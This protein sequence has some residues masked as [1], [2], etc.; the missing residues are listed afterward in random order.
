MRCLGEPD[1]CQCS[2]S[3]AAATQC[4]SA[5]GGVGWE[6][7]LAC[8]EDICRCPLQIDVRFARISFI[9]PAPSKD[10]ALSPIRRNRNC[11]TCPEVEISPA[12]A[13]TKGLV[14]VVERLMTSTQVPGTRDHQ[15]PSS[16]PPPPPHPPQGEQQQ[17]Q[18]IVAGCWLCCGGD[19]HLLVGVTVLYV[20][21]VNATRCT[22]IT[23][24][25]GTRKAVSAL[26]RMA[27]SMKLIP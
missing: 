5:E 17:E 25:P 22:I 24:T 23:T 8:I 19:G 18:K 16:P 20:Y 4:R 13:T 6:R 9:P 7:H 14:Q 10:I 12:S 26:T 11:R 3:E 1:C 21:L 2:G 15:P 27:F